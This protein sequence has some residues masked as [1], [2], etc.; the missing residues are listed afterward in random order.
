MYLPR[1]RIGREYTPPRPQRTGEN[2]MAA[3][4]V[5]SG[6]RPIATA[7]AL[8]CGGHREQGIHSRP[9]PARRSLDTVGVGP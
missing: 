3:G 2:A 6:Q 8:L 4:G 5:A 9:T 1:P 7:N